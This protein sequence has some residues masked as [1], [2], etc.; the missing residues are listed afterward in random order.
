MA[1]FVCFLAARAAK[2]AG[3][4]NRRAARDAGAAA[5][6]RVDRNAHLDSEGRR[7]VRARHRRDSLDRRRRRSSAWTSRR[8]S[9]RS[10][11][12]ARTA[13]C[14]S[15]S[16]APPARVSTGAVDPLAEIAAVCR[17]H[18]VWFHVD[19]AYGA[20]AARVP[21]APES[22]RAL[23]RRRL[24]RRRSAQVAV[25]AAR[26]GLRAGASAAAICVRAF[27]Y[28]P[29][30]YH[31]DHEVTNYFDYGPQNSRGFRALKVWLA[32]RQVGL[33]GLSADDRRRHAPVEA[34]AHARAAASGL[35][36]ADAASQHHDVPLRPARP[37]ADGGHA[38]RPNSICSG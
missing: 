15:S 10:S 35:R 29:S 23:E 36:G 17:R 12:T 7:P 3:R 22:L 18:D 21:G 27:S 19:G 5:R 8:S 6:L 26:S 34:S 13:R 31:F 16:S 4:A 28:H 14:R 24:R 37:A 33:V 1:N 30:Y 11:P 20:L 9:G 38:G 25:R 32:L 2:A